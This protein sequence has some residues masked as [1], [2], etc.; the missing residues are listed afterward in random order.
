MVSCGQRIIWLNRISAEMLQ[1]FGQMPCD[2][3]RRDGRRCACGNNGESVSSKAACGLPV[4][5]KDLG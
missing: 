1:S 4:K 2:T 5:I 3:E